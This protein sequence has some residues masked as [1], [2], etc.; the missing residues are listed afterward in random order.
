MKKIIKE[1][2]VVEGKS[3]TEK[4]VKLFSV[5]TIE[6]NGLS[7]NKN[8]I[9]LIKQI[10]SKQGVI[11]FLDP[12]GPGEKI[13][14]VLQENIGSCKNAFIDKKKCKYK[15]KV[16]IAETPDEVVIEAIE[17]VVTFEIRKESITWS[18]YIQ[19]ELNSKQ[20][21]NKITNHYMIS[22]CNNKTLFKRLNMMS[23]TKDDIK[24]IL[25]K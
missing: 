2:I 16:G 15:K 6:T 5:E 14:R 4:L 23:V 1:V 11:L 8:T 12:D 21:R 20:R 25:C 24:E 10:N 3:D 9:N 22:E 19:L 17:N 13:R 18:E 7:L